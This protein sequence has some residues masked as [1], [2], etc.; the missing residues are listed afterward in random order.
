MAAYLIA[1][2]DVTDAERYEDYKEL[3]PAAIEAH[4]GTYLVRGGAHETVEGEP[5]DRR[6]VVLEFE[7]AAA[8]RAFYHSPEYTAARSVREGAATGQFVIVEGV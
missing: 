1:R 8:A 4:G 2:I 7:D 3:A 5:E 6:I